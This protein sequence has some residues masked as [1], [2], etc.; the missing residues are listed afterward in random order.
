M[1]IYEIFVN[2]KKFVH[3]HWRLITLL[4]IFAC[5]LFLR[6]Y[7]LETKSTFGW[8]QVDNAW[9]A[10]NIIVDHKLLLQGMQAKGNSGIFIGPLYYYLISIVYFF[11]NLDP[12]ASGI[13]AGVTAFFS[14][15]AIYFVFKKVLGIGTALIG[16]F[17]YTFSMYAIN[18]DRVQ[19]PVNFIVPVSILFFY[20]LYELIK[21]KEKFL[22]PLSIILGF[23]F[24][25]HFT[26]IFYPIIFILCLPLIPR[27][28]KTIVYGLVGFSIFLLFISPILV[29]LL[30]S[31]SHTRNLT[32]Y[33]GTYNHGF[34]L[35]RMMQIFFDALIEFEGVLRIDAIK[36]FGIFILLGFV[37]VLYKS[38]NIKD[39]YKL[40]YLI[41]LWFLVPWSIFT[42]YSG[43][44]SNY[45]FSINLPI[46]VMAMAFLAV[47]ILNSKKKA[48]IFLLLLFGF[49]WT[50]Q[51]IVEFVKN[52]EIGLG[53]YRTIVKSDIAEGKIINF[54]E[55][56]PKSYLYY[57]YKQRKK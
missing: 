37:A 15:F 56:D 30:D 20:T 24:H 17:I 41:S 46:A 44:L 6:F 18:F 45:Y 35:R 50:F 1:K 25:I 8:D 33:G 28:K 11:T 12:I 27:T 31:S 49:Y 54:Q 55:G 57:V 14:F 47:N 51:N 42:M 13:F 3:K 9:A 53:D 19:W 38:R 2:M 32:Q 52:K 21:G 29:S 43:E 4:S 48:A 39:K 23:S 7:L 22:I 5:F 26:S 10:K 36:R 34:H 16:V 40:L